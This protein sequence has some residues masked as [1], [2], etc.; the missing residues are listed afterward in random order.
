MKSMH[1]VFVRDP[2]LIIPCGGARILGGGDHMT[3]SN[4][5][6]YNF[7]QENIEHSLAEITPALQAKLSVSIYSP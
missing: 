4:Y 1:D 5:S 6:S 3:F 7:H 2:L